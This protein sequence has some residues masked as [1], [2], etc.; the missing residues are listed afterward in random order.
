MSPTHYPL[1]H[2]DNFYKN[3]VQ[4]KHQHTFLA[5][6]AKKNKE[7]DL[8]IFAA[9]EIFNNLLFIKTSFISVINKR[10]D[11]NVSDSLNK[12]IST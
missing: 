1:H 11:N 5:N 10:S 7:N 12:I 3:S 4:K 6:Y 8:Q 9:K 2:S